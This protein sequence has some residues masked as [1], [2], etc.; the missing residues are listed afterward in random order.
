[1]RKDGLSW[2]IVLVVFLVPDVAVH[3]H[4]KQGKKTIVGTASPPMSVVL[5]VYLCYSV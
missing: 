2:I 3:R 4:H 5:D 1:M